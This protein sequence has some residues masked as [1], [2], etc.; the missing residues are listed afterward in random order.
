[1]LALW[2]WAAFVRTWHFLLDS[3]KSPSTMRKAGCSS[4]NVKRN[5]QRGGCVILKWRNY[6]LAFGRIAPAQMHKPVW[7]VW[8]GVLHILACSALCLGW[9]STFLEGSPFST[10]LCGFRGPWWPLL[11]SSLPNTWPASVWLGKRLPAPSTGLRATGP[12]LSIY[13][14]CWLSSQTRR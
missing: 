3:T 2:F 5:R 13:D 1:M 8:G 9:G 7:H 10:V 14:L 6:F 4:L 12:L 11:N